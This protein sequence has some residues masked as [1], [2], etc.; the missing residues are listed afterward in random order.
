[1][2]TKCNN[3]NIKTLHK[4]KTCK[5]KK[6]CAVCKQEGHSAEDFHK[7]HRIM[8]VL[9]L[10]QFKLNDEC[11]NHEHLNWNEI[12]AMYPKGIT[13]HQINKFM[14]ENGLNKTRKEMKKLD[15]ELMQ[16]NYGK[17]I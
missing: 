9:A 3:S 14:K 2:C 10:M 15:Q 8:Q 4:A 7:C 17:M 6:Q 13:I 1:M 5:Y 16:K 11:P 12:Q